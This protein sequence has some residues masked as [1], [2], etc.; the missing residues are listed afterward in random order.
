MEL[1]SLLWIFLLTLVHAFPGQGSWYLSNC[2]SL[3]SSLK[4]E[5]KKDVKKDISVRRG[6]VSENVALS[7]SPG[8]LHAV[9]S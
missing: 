7:P 9:T 1:N 5:L 6:D 3:T 2:I 8:N 4:M